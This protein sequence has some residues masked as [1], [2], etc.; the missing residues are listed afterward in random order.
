MQSHTFISATAG[1]VISGGNYTHTFQGSSAPIEVG[2]GT[3]ADPYY[4]DA[5]YI[6][7]EGTPLT[8]TNAAYAP[9]TGIVTL[10]VPTL[11]FTPSDAAYS[12]ASGDMQITLG[13]NHNLT[14]YDSIKITANS[15]S[16]S[17]EYN[18]VTQTKTYPRATGAATTNGADY[19]YDVFLP[20]L[21]V[22]AT[23]VTVNV[24]GGQGVISHNVQK[25]MTHMGV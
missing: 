2:V 19:A 14:T 18:G 15:L 1:A 24:N 25:N 12:P 8:A 10:T 9:D 6:K 5:A 7:Y 21:K 16:F 20:I 11:Q 13:A 23:S 4:D 22:D 3:I 17:C